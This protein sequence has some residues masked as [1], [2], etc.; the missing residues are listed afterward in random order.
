MSTT[1]ATQPLDDLEPVDVR[2]RDV[3]HDQIRCARRD[4]G[5]RL[6]TVGRGVD[7]ETDETQTDRDQIGDVL[8]V[9]DDEDPHSLW[10]D[11]QPHRRSMAT[12][13]SDRLF[14]T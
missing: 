7:V 4:L 2:H 8:L 9:V 6:A 5:Q 10:I 13:P 11:R 3:E 12:T 1:V 14:T